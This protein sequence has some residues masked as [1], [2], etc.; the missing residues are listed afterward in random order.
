[1]EIDLNADLGEGFGPWR[2]GDDEA[3]LDVLSSANVACGFHAGDPLIMERTVRIGAG[4]RRRRRRACRLSRPPGLRP[5]RRCR[6]TPAELAA[7]VTY[8]LGALAGIAR[9]AGH[10]MTH[11]S[12]HGALG[13]MAA[14]DA[15]LAGPLVRG[16]GAASIRTSSSSPRPAAPSRT[17]PRAAACGSRRPSWPTA[18]ATTTGLLVPRRLPDSVIHDEAAVL[19]RVR[20]LLR[21]GIVDD[22]RRH[23]CCRCGPQ[24]ILR[25]RRHA[26]RG[27]A[28]A[29][30][31]RRRSRRP[32]GRVVPVS[33]PGTGSLARPRIRARLSLHRQSV[34]ARDRPHQLTSHQQTGT[35]HAVLRLQDRSRHRRLV[36]H[37]RRRRRAALP[38]GAARS[39]PSPAAPSALAELAERTGCIAHAIDVTD[40][41]GARRGSP[42]RSSSTSWSTTPASTGRS[43]S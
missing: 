33:Q 42:A 23:G 39:T 24:S 28:G 17:R 26:G 7:M 3:L 30:H 22:L 2:M 6:S 41:R 13:N 21:E 1:M 31:P 27:G 32:G 4:A 20:R 25:A 36:R 15:A 14:A 19:E 40:T 16:R 29:R 38:R 5:P 8:Q 12:F 18:P 37:R 35:D 9:A 43:P 11:M 34:L 10:R